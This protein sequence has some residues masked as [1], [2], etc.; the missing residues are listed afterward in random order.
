MLLHVERVSSGGPEKLAHFCVDEGLSLATALSSAKKFTSKKHF[1]WIKHVEHKV[2]E[3]SKH[4]LLML[5]YITLDKK[6]LEW[7]WN[8]AR[9][10]GKTIT[11]SKDPEKSVSIWQITAHL[12]INIYVVWNTY[13][14]Q[15]KGTTVCVWYCVYTTELKMVYYIIYI[16]EKNI[17]C[18]PSVQPQWWKSISICFIVIK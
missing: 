10:S 4:Y 12:D 13:F 6:A 17:H 18:W 15:Y 8:S 14:T 5:C 16:W 7:S 2:L 11:Q 3:I 9:G 1:S